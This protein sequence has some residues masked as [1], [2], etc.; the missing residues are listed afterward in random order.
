MFCQNCGKE[1]G[2][3]SE[4]CPFCGTATGVAA[5]G[6]E[7]PEATPMTPQ[8]P[9]PPPPV[10]TQPMPPGGAPPPMGGGIPP[11][12]YAPQPK[13]SPLPWILA[14]VGVLAVI[15]VVLVLVFVVFKGDGGDKDTAGPENVVE[16]FF[17]SM[18][19]HDAK[20][21]TST[22][23]PDYAKQ[24]EDILGADYVDLLDEYFFMYFPEGLDI[25]ID[26]MDTQIDGDK[27]QVKIVSGTVSY[28]DESGE[29]VTE[30]A[31]VMD[32]DSFDLVKVNGKWYISEDTLVA[33]GFDFSGLMD[34]ED[35]NLDDS[36]DFSDDYSTGSVVLPVDSED[37]VVTLIL[38]D[39]DIWDWYLNTDYPYYDITDENTSYGVYLYE[40]TDDGTEIPFGWYAV[41]KETGE[42]FE[43]VQ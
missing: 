18:E 3:D 32:M 29:K 37:E 19:K 27:A 14:G 7:T 28:I 9:P 24:L 38:D 13:K 1:I 22:M 40:I 11:T 21:L 23:E 2:G 20:L 6:A 39:P 17:E 26:K 33:M 16:T 4:F 36:T 12:P 35:M 31:D 25:K 5:G 43:V 30:E 15:A 8:A 41:D 42:I 10:G 34:L